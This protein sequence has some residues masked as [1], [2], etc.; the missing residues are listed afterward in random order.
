[1]NE[2]EI[3]KKIDKNEDDSIFFR[4]RSGYKK[5]R[6]GSIKS[7][8]DF[9]KKVI[10]L[11]DIPLITLSEE[12][13]PMN[14]TIIKL[15]KGRSGVSENIKEKIN[16]NIPIRNLQEGFENLKPFFYLLDDGDYELRE[17][18]MIPTDGENN[19]FWDSGRRGRYYNASA[20]MYY[21]GRYIKGVPK[22]LVPSEGSERFDR[23]TVDYYRKKIKDGEELVGIALELKGFMALLLDGHH[24]ATAAYLEGEN[25]KCLT[26]KCCER[27]SEI[28]NVKE[29]EYD[30][31]KSIN[32]TKINIEKPKEVFPDF[33][34]IAVVEKNIDTS[35]N[36]IDKL[37]KFQSN[38]PIE[39]LK[40]ILFYFTIY[41]KPKAKK[42]C[43]EILERNDFQII[44]SECLNYLSRYEDSEVSILFKD[45]M[46]NEK[47]KYSKN[48]EKNLYIINRFFNKQIN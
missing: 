24:K 21:N 12:K 4:V 22:F 10:L 33:K 43:F 36:R 20:D 31:Y 44:W 13:S 35:R 39:E 48:F 41:D 15:I 25:L 5:L 42:L 18:E 47:I 6:E 46:Y 11:D 9:H 28:L 45:M 34:A 17:L 16:L 2:D 26:I 29:D 7:G 23:N 27:Y 30:K 32:F 1:M 8:N 14:S 40:E 3:I 37:F 38:A 19:Y